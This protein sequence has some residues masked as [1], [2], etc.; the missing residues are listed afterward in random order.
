MRQSFAFAP[1]PCGH[2]TSWSKQVIVAIEAAPRCPHPRMPENTQV[3]TEGKARAMQIDDDPEV[4]SKNDDTDHGGPADTSHGVA[5]QSSCIGVEQSGARIPDSDAK[6]IT[7]ST[8]RNFRI[9]TQ[10]FPHDITLLSEN[11][12]LNAFDWSTLLDLFY[13]KAGT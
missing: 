10:R 6:P 4:N 1:R 8:K 11:A 9:F 5:P 13:L 12:G 2:A 3:L 7:A